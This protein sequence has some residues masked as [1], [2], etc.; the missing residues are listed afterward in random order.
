MTLAILT[1]VLLFSTC[2]PAEVGGTVTT[3]Q[4][5]AD[6]NKVLIVFLSRTNNTKAL[7][8]IIQKNVGGRLVALELETQ[9]VEISKFL[10][11]T[12]TAL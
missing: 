11:F 5:T 10:V 9:P 6:P 12:I 1:F 8:E 7:A 3:T 2:S 4:S